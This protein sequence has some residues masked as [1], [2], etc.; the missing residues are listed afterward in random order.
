MASRAAKLGQAVLDLIIDDS[1]FH[2]SLSGAYKAAQSFTDQTGKNLTRAG[3]AITGVGESWTRNITAPIALAG[4]VVTKFG[5]DFDTT[6]SEVVALTSVTE[7]QIGGIREELIK[8]GPEVGK[9]PQ[10]LAEAFYFVASAGFDGAEALDVLKVSAKAASAGLGDTSTVAKVVGTAINAYGRE[11][12]TAAEA[13]DTLVAAIGEGSAEAPEFAGALGNVIGSAAQ[14]GASF[15]DVTAAIAAMTNVGIGAEEAVTSLNQVFV[16]LFKPTKEAEEALADMGLSAAQ[17]RTMIAEQGL[18]PTLQLLSD[19]FEG[20]AEATATVFGNVRALRG[21]LALTGGD[22]EKTAGIFD[23]MQE[24][25]GATG[26]AFDSVAKS[27]AFKFRQEMA[28]LQATA[29]TIGE[30]VL[31]IVVRVLGKVGDAAED[32]SEWWNT[33]DHDTKELIISSLAW[34]AIAGP[35][36]VILGK[37]TTGVGDLFKVVAFLSGSRGIPKLIAKLGGLRAAL[38]AGGVIGLLIAL[39]AGIREVSGEAEHMDAMTRFADTL[40][41]AGISAD[42]ARKAMEKSGLSVG[43]FVTAF[44]ELTDAGTDAGDALDALA[45]N[46]AIE[47]WAEDQTYTVEEAAESFDRAMMRQADAAMDGTAATADALAGLPPEVRS[48]LEE[49]G[50]V[51]DETAPQTFEGMVAAARDAAKATPEAIVGEFVTGKITVEQAANELA[52]LIPAPLRAAA[53]EAL[54]IALALPG[55]IAQSILDGRDAVVTAATGLGEAATDP[56]VN[57]ARIDETRRQMQEIVDAVAEGGGKWTAQQQADYDKA[58]IMLAGYLLRA[59]PKS[60]EAMGLLAKYAKAKDPATQEAY[61]ALVAAIEDRALVLEENVE[62]RA[63]ATGEALPDALA[64]TKADV[65]REAYLHFLST[66]PPAQRMKDDVT[67][68]A[69]ETARATRE[70]LDAEKVRTGIAAEDVA[71]RVRSPLAHL[72][73]D[74]YWWGFGIPEQMARGIKASQPKVLDSVT[75]AIPAL[76]NGIRG[77]MPGSEPSN[78]NSALRGITDAFGFVDVLAGGLR[79]VRPLDDAMRGI[80]AAMTLDPT[81]PAIGSPNLPTLATIDGP[82][83]VADRLGGIGGNTYQWILQVEGRPPEVVDGPRGAVERLERIGSTWG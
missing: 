79:D 19:K 23:R 10:E 45:D 65:E 15:A 37:L 29:I 81:V 13:T 58:E 46:R 4:G 54:G 16:S 48:A 18:L 47:D 1:K 78:P 61:E 8:L 43:E 68:L 80:S 64:R 33:L 55:D 41:D 34:I 40:S 12:I 49:A 76:A 39:A 71:S 51:I 2:S 72:K 67:D 31:P 14:I 53:L 57:Q 26:D 7:D 59:D 6:M 27:D 63:A 42:K 83:G 9:S 56:L 28:K 77:Y 73:D 66:I 50:L 24:T 17:L 69:S 35:V 25:V 75:G 20:N 52:A 38:T 5:L 60:E 11:N 32:L 44:L 62:E 3:K 70:R 82:T 36:L 21:V 30:D 74:A 22:V